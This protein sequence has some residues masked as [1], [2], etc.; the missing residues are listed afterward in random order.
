MV[1]VLL[2]LLSIPAISALLP[3]G[4]F[5]THDGAFHLVRLSHFYNEIARGQFPV[6]VGTEMAFG[7]GYPIFNYFYPLLYYLGSFFHFLGLSLGESLK[8][9]IA[10]ATLGSVLAFYKW[11]RCHFDKW[12]S[13]LGALFYLYTPY[14]FVATYVSGNFGTVLD[15]LF[16]PLV[17]LSVFGMVIKKKNFYFLSFSLSLALL[18]LSHN[19][20]A[21]IFLPF[22]IFYIFFLMYQNRSGKKTMA[23]LI[24]AV[25]LTIGLSSFFLIPA[26]FELHYVQLSTRIAENFRDHFVTLRQLI[27]SKWGYGYS[28]V[29]ENDGISFQIG[30]AQWIVIALTFV[31][32]LVKKILLK[33]GDSREGLPNE[34]S[35]GITGS[36]IS[37]KTALEAKFGKPE[38]Q[39]PQIKRNDDYLTIL[40]F[41]IFLAAVFLMLPQSEIIWSNIKIMQQIQFPWRLLALVMVCTS[42][43]TVWLVTKLKSFWII[44]ILSIILIRGNINNLRPMDT[45]RYPDSYYLENIGLY[46]GSTDTSWENLPMG[47]TKAPKKFLAAKF[48]AEDPTAKITEIAQSAS[49]KLRLN[50]QSEKPL[51][52]TLNTFYFP[53]WQVTIDGKE[54]IISPNPQGLIELQVP[55]GNHQVSL[56]LKN[57]PLERIADMISVVSIFSTIGLFACMCY[58]TRLCQKS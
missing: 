50:I 12:P 48:I 8:I 25:I 40:I 22:I 53:M 57:T 17:L 37:K 55:Q 34:A 15:F 1:I 56:R 16:L 26:I 54:A 38:R 49:E 30:I 44:I 4:Y 29:G 52:L 7:Y 35:L 10:L 19:I 31:I 32:F 11:L 2:L 43:L 9:I 51:T 41:F 5:Y 45:T 47:V 20:S 21:L 27:Y 3:P 46:F 6:R 39:D 13:F 28:I 36:L 24:F 58:N 23:K 33:A 18:I 14:R 42:F